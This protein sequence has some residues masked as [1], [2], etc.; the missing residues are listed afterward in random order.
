MHNLSGRQEAVIIMISV[1]YLLAL[2][3]L[4]RIVVRRCNRL[5]V[6]PGKYVGLILASIFILFPLSLIWVS[7]WSIRTLTAPTSSND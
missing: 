3:S 4:I 1:A 6:G 2:F 5:E 7:F